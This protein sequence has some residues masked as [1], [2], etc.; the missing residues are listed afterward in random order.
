MLP[1]TPL[2]AAPSWAATRLPNRSPAEGVARVASRARRPGRGDAGRTAGAALAAASAGA[3]ARPGRG[4]RGERR[5]KTARR[6]EEMELDD[7]P[8]ELGAEVL[9]EPQELSFMIEEIP[10]R[11][12]SSLII[13]HR[14]GSESQYQA[15]LKLVEEYLPKFDVYNSAAALHKCA[16]NARDDELAARQIQSDPNFAR[17]FTAAKKQTLARV[18]DLEATTLT[19]V[20]WACARLNIFDSEL[21]T[22]IAADATTRMNHYSP[23]SIGLLMFS[24]GY[25]GTRPKPSLMKALIAELQGRPDFDT[26]S[27][28]LIVYACMRLGIRDRRIMEEIGKHIEETQLSDCQPLNLA[29][30]CYTYGKLEYWERKAVS[31]LARQLT[32]V[33]EDFSPRMLCMS[34]MGLAQAAGQLEDVDDALDRMKL[35][36]EDRMADLTH[37]EVSTLAFAFGKYALL[38]RE[39]KAAIEGR[40]LERKKLSVDEN[41]T[42]EIDPFVKALKDEVI[43]RDHESWTMT[44]LNLIVYA[45]MR[46]EHRDE[47]F[48]EISALVFQKGAAELMLVEILNILYS[49]GRLDF[50]NVSLVERLLQEL[51]RRNEYDSFEPSHWATLAYS[52]AINQVR[53]EPLMDRIALHFC[54]HIR[55]YEDQS[56]QMTLYGLAVLNCRNHGEV[57]ASAAAEELARRDL[58]NSTLPQGIFAVALLAGPSASLHVMSL[59]FRPGFWDRDFAELGYTMLYH[60]MASWQ[61]ELKLPVQELVGHTVCRRCY[62]EATA[63]YMG[64]Q[65]RRLSDRLRIQQI[66]HQA[67]CMVSALDGFAEAGVRG[68]ICIPKIK[69]IIEVEGPQRNTVPLEL[70]MDKL[71][72][73]GSKLNGGDRGEV[74]S[75]AREHVECGLS[76]SAAFKRR[77]LRS[78]GWRV[79]TVSFDESEEYIADALK[80]MIKKGPGEDEEVPEAFPDASAYDSI[81]DFDPALVKPNENDISDFELKLRERHAEAMEKLQ[82]RLLEERE[83]VASASKYSDYLQFRQWQVQLEK[84]I[85]KEMVEGLAEA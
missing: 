85:L 51:E 26:N 9:T 64:E 14:L 17:L 56:L 45:L 1:A 4:R 23:M 50:L 80:K 34:A 35:L 20:L 40:R 8:L 68:D 77:L 6:A 31:A 55:E 49:Y 28:V 76:G 53:H 43:R 2:A 27:L 58:T 47:D 18:S 7:V 15:V 39:R 63:T 32:Q 37:R 78:C 10:S 65:H 42:M 16:I 74:L 82:L 69:L 71:R 30:L 84:E 67:N 81:Q 54:E 83:N 33:M 22:A 72:E 44:E 62:E 36:V 19:T 11:S 52:L 57:V 24:M 48:L 79:V 75:Q 5:A 3:F 70:L 21:T 66:P 61:A 46:M 59:M 12:S 29:C 25:S 41:T 38:A 73:V 13:H 60:L